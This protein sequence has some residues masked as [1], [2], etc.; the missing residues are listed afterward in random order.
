M[1]NFNFGGFCESM[2]T[3][4]VVSPSE[5]AVKLYKTARCHT[6]YDHRTVKLYKTARCHTPYDLRTVK[7]YKTARCHIPYDHRIIDN[8][9]LQYC[10]HIAFNTAVKLITI[11]TH[12]HLHYP[13]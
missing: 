2:S 7:L 4:L 9:C 8:L 3:M 5:M 13:H 1:K 6:P 11:S 12:N 10:S